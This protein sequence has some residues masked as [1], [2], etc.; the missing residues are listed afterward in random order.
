MRAIHARTKPN[1]AVRG[2]AAQPRDIH[3]DHPNSGS[4][5]GEL[6]DLYGAI[7]I[8]IPLA[9]WLKSLWS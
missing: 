7:L 5:E 9:L 2:A 8:V 6:F 1:A 3:Q 4:L